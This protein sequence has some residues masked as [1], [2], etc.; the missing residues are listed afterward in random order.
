MRYFFRV[1]Y[2]GTGYGGWQHQKSTPNIQDALERAFSTVVRAP[3]RI[4]GAGR[5]DAGVHARAQGAHVDVDGPL[6]IRHSEHSVNAL[7]P[8]DIAV[9]ALQQVDDSFHARFSAVSR[10]YCYRICGRKRPLL[11][12]RVWPVFYKID[13]DRVREEAASL[14]GVHD[15]SAFCASGSDVRHA[16]CTVLSARF[17]PEG[18]CMVFAIEANRFVYTMVRS[19][20]GTLVDMGRGKIIE[21][22]TDILAK[23]DRARAGTTAPACGLTLEKVNYQGVD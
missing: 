18:D 10:S 22:M 19:L 2:D 15:F 3:C 1:E 14:S 6:R 23:K 16:R 21:S 9:Y 7:L 11:F 13:H 4:T 8:S 20:V 17:E 12:N 5:T